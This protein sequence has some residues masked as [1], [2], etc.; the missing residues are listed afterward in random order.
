[1]SWASGVEICGKIFS[2]IKVS[3]LIQWHIQAEKNLQTLQ[4]TDLFP[5]LSFVELFVVIFPGIL[6]ASLLREM[7]NFSIFHPTALL[8]VYEDATSQRQHCE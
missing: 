6:L 8:V 2:I 4:F 7:Q 1:M 5:T 3:C